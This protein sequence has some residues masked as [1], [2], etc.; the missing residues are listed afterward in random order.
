MTDNNGVPQ[1]GN[2]ARTLGVRPGVD[3]PIDADG[4]VFA[5]C[6]DMGKLA[7]G[8]IHRQDKLNL[9]LNELVIDDII[10]RIA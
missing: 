1:V 2:T 8:K 10:T 5:F 7:K 6:Q 3:I 4:M 9:T